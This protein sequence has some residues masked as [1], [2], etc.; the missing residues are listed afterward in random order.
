MPT[1]AP[2]NTGA[3]MSLGNQVYNQLPGYGAS[4][5][6]VGAN[7]QSETAG[8]LPQDVITQLQQRA[9]ERGIGT[10]TQGSDNNNA[11]YLRALGL[12]S[13]D[14]TNMGQ[15]NLDKQLPLLP[16]AQIY[17]N[18]AFYP[19]SGQAYESDLQSNI[20]A[21][22][23]NPAAAGN[24][25]LRAAQGGYAAGRGSMGGQ[26][27]PTPS[28]GPTGGSGGGFPVSQPAYGSGV[29][30]GGQT[31]SPSQDVIDRILQSYSDT[32]GYGGGTGGDINNAGT[33]FG[34]EAG[35]PNDY[36]PAGAE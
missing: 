5:G 6:N 32:V 25:N 30:P 19:T 14:L 12:T 7:V 36:Y 10:G 9:A 33:Y 20:F 23:P 24:A 1:T 35:D 18:P 3:A 21:S 31:G 28:Y 13:L 11:A 34:S 26:L 4:I 2:V 17:Q 15:A 27:P 22:A 8:Q 16:G 29:N